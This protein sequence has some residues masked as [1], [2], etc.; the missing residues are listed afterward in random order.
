[1]NLLTT[2]LAVALALVTVVLVVIV[3]RWRQPAR[4]AARDA[5]ARVEGP[6]PA[7]AEPAAAEAVRQRAVDLLGIADTPPEDRFD[8]IVTMARQLYHTDSAVFSVIDR[9]RE[10]HKSRSGN[11]VEEVARTS[12][13]CSVAIRGVSSLVVGDASLD[14]RFR[15]TPSVVD[16]PNLRFYAGMPVHSA[17]GETIGALCVYDPVPREASEVDDTLLRQLAHL[18]ELELRV[19]PNSEARQHKR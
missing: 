12:S 17:S 8:R 6:R 3:I 2:A 18:I 7:S 9:D 1:M 19:Y 13:F 4:I 16:D 14:A 10:W 11:T 5:R 15:D